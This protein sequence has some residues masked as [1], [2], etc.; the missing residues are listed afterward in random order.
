LIGDRLETDIRGA[1]RVGMDSAL[2]LTGVTGREDV[3]RGDP[4]PTWVAE[5]LATLVGVKPGEDRSP[6]GSGG[7]APPSPRRP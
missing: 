2:V 3:E 4:K 5:S 1:A 7:P 6:P